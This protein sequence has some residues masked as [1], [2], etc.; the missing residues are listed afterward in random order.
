MMRLHTLF[1]VFFDTVLIIGFELFCLL[2]GY[3]AHAR[4]VRAITFIHCNIITTVVCLQC[5]INVLYV[6]KY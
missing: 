5:S 6:N 1:S 4:V 2:L 3:Y